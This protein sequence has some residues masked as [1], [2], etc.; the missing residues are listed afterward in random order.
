MKRLVLFLLILFPIWAGADCYCT[1]IKGQNQAI[2]DSA[3][4]DAQTTSTTTSETGA[5][6]GEFAELRGFLAISPKARFDAAVNAG[7]FRVL[8][9]E[10]YLLEVPPHA[11]VPCY[12]VH[13]IP[14]TTDSPLSEE[15]AELIR[16]ARAYAAE[17]NLLLQQKP[18]YRL[19]LLQHILDNLRAG[20]LPNKRLHWPSLLI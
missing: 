11:Q 12:G 8:M 6:T 7:D 1:C 10:G 17:Y 20:T 19:R 18:L 3:I 16:R 2:C 13:V 15:H 9:V 4:G 5:L 14:Q